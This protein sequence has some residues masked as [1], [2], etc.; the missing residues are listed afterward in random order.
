M[1]GTF[2]ESFITDRNHILD[3]PLASASGCR[4][5]HCFGVTSDY[6]VGADRR[7][8]GGE[9]CRCGFQQAQQTVQSCVS[10]S[11]RWRRFVCHIQ[12]ILSKKTQ[13]DYSI[14][15]R[16]SIN[17]LPQK[18]CFSKSRACSR[19]VDKSDWIRL[20]SRCLRNRTGNVPMVMASTHPAAA[21]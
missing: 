3:V 16:T 8:A 7:Y 11:R 2:N 9:R 4:A 21:E 18:C 10:E 14:S 12:P 20:R 19:T 15:S 1:L 5:E 13:N 6:R 17:D